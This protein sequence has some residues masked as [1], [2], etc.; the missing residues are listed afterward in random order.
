MALLATSKWANLDLDLL[1]HTPLCSS[2]FIRS[3][4][5]SSTRLIKI[6]SLYAVYVFI[7]GCTKSDYNYDNDFAEFEKS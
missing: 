1:H 3:V 7:Q 5:Y 2:L 6:D 4:L